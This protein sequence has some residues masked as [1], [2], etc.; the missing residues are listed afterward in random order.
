M[1]MEQVKQ[2]ILSF[3]IKTGKKHRGVWNRLCQSTFRKRL[4]C[5]LMVAVIFATQTDLLRVFAETDEDTSTGVVQIAGFQELPAEVAEQTVALGTPYE[6]LLLPE[7]LTAYAA[8]QK[9]DSEE[10]DTEEDGKQ[11][12]DAE[13]DGTKEDGKQENGTEEDNSQS[14]TEEDSASG[15]IET[16]DTVEDNTDG[17]NTQDGSN[18]ENGTEADDSGAD[19]ADIS[20]DGITGGADTDG[21]VTEQI[22]DVVAM[23]QT[24]DMVPWEAKTSTVTLPEY[25]SENV[26]TVETLLQNPGSETITVTGVTWE[27]ETVYDNETPGQYIFTPVLPDGYS[28][29][30]GITL[31]EITVTV[32]QSGER[33]TAAVRTLRAGSHSH[34]LCGTDCTHG[35]GSQNYTA[36]ST[37]EGGL[38]A[39]SYY[40]ETD[41]EFTNA[42]TISGTVNLCLNGHSIYSE[43]SDG[44]IRVHNN[45]V[46]NICD[47]GNG[48]KIYC[49]Q[50]HNP[51]QLSS[52][53]TLNLYGG[54]I[55]SGGATAIPVGTGKNDSSGG[56]TINIYGGAV[57]GK[58]Q[59]ILINPSMSGTAVNVYGGRI[60]AVNY[61][62]R[63][64]NGSVNL[65]GGNISATST[66]G[67]GISAE[68]STGVTLSGNAAISGIAA[69][70]SIASP[71]CDNG[72][73]GGNVSID[74]TNDALFVVN[75]V[76]VQNG[77]VNSGKYSLIKKYT[78]S[79]W[80]LLKGGNKGRDLVLH[81]H[82][83]H[84]Y[85]TPVWSW[86]G[87]TSA[88]AEFTCT[89][90]SCGYKEN[91]TTTAGGI[92]SK[93]TQEATCTEK[94]SKTY[95]ASVVFEGK[96]YTDTKIEEISVKPF[97]VTFDANGGTGNMGNQT[98][99]YGMPQTISMNQ[100][101]RNGYTFNGWN[102]KKTGGGD[103]FTDG[104]SLVSYAP[105]S[106]TAIT[107]YA[108]WNPNQYV[109]TFDY[110]G[111]TG[112]NTT[113]RME[114][115]YDSAY[116][117]LPQPAKSGYTF[118][119]WYTQADGKGTK[120]TSSTKVTIDKDHKLYA[121]WKDNRIKVLFI[122]NN[123]EY[124]TVY[125]SYGGRITE[126]PTVP[127][128]QDAGDDNYVGEWCDAQGNPAVFTNITADMTVY[129]VYTV[130][131][132]ITLQAGAGYRLNPSSDS[133]GLVKEGNSYSFVFTLDSGY[134]KNA[135]FAVKINGVKVELA[136]G[137]S[138]TI[139]DV[140]ENKKVTVEGVEQ[141][142]AAGGN[143]GSSG[144]NSTGGSGENGGTPSSGSGE[145]GGTPSGGGIGDTSTGG[146]GNNSGTPSGS[147]GTG[148]G[149]TTDGENN[150]E[151][152]NGRTD[153]GTTSD[154]RNNGRVNTGNP[155]ADDTPAEH[156]ENRADEQTKDNSS[157]GVRQGIPEGEEVLTVPVV[158]DNGR[159]IVNADDGITEQAIPTGN[160]AGMS[161]TST[162][163]K[164]GDGAVVVT[165]ICTEQDYSAGV[166]DTAAVANAVLT[167]THMELVSNG[168]IIE[169]R[170]DMKDISS[171][172]PEQDKEVIENGVEAYSEE[173]PGLTL[174]MYVDISMF[175]RN[176][177]EDWKAVT[178]TTEPIAVVIGIPEGLLEDGREY[179]IIRAHD[180]EYTLMNDT[181]DASDTITINTDRFS[182]YAI[183]WQETENAGIKCGF[184]HICP[185]FL[186]ICCFVWLAAAAVIILIVFVII[187]A[188]QREAEESR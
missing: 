48:G 169:I 3:Y 116:G 99:T 36:L 9:T 188:R 84:T 167:Q 80:G 42:L 113:K 83:S 71:I 163:L 165:V 130:G 161:N 122:A 126:I 94:G 90:A 58:G 147:S 85:A 117:T 104:A 18:Q 125:T 68:N 64:Q 95:T 56:C 103:A 111:A 81:T 121:C 37:T 25:Q 72:Y 139:T 92:T 184:C 156:T 131:Y 150:R 23:P 43:V 151:D 60:N 62:I 133:S 31:P 140:R 172:V 153:I 88:S 120:V 114:V 17:N 158:I 149:K 67:I 28:L 108:Q 78:D 105:A 134:R 173:I 176:G 65:A 115:N 16:D 49:L 127:E 175:V 55:E 45:S 102:T 96:T 128:K 33:R 91:V 8:Y 74:I 112:G 109:V 164:L 13:E 63:A 142:P 178:E 66:N 107:L 51:I 98:F 6:E 2:R 19:E 59:A 119:G 185:A 168:E 89:V 54:T 47:C 20:E 77:A 123:E 39:G 4:A 183:A 79:G 70:L 35:H 82:L 93:V 86:T 97:T 170:I 162:V 160:A 106:G 41:F 145:T 146:N 40:L 21:N 132:T 38:S 144:G 180:G 32:E 24:P 30:G 138:Y 182:S 155:V 171:Q 61:G 76:L 135:D 181:D 141:I 57:Q 34:P 22:P 1:Y 118:L 87:Y 15:K 7:E 110:Q 179:Y 12:D 26:V 53:G 124:T 187:R 154:N 14:E 152:G 137:G 157:V 148:N 5:V 129:A 10:N 69:A 27:S 177:Q 186:G 52:G 136:S 44:V 50:S 159:I 166:E 100:F 29:A 174:G 73:T 143:Q 46:L 11:E 75:T 101:I